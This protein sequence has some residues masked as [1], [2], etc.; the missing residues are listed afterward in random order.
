MQI[1]V[2]ILM[3][4]VLPGKLA[5]Q[6]IFLRYRGEKKLV[7]LSQWSKDEK[8]KKGD[9]CG[10]YFLYEVIRDRQLV[11]AKVPLTEAEDR[12][13]FVGLNRVDRQA[14]QIQLDDEKR[15]PTA[16]WVWPQKDFAAGAK[17]LIRISRQDYDAAPCLALADAAKAH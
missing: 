2:A 3:L 13:G 1:R 16:E 14:I 12:N 9:P 11:T 7:D 15:A 5:A 10:K 17:M 8:A 6:P 4:L